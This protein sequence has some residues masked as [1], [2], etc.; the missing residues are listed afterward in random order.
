MKVSQNRANPLKTV[1]PDGDW[2]LLIAVDEAENGQLA[3][4]A[5]GTEH[6]S[7]KA[8]VDRSN[9]SGGATETTGARHNVG[10]FSYGG[11]ESG[12]RSV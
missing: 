7:P 1:R 2:M 8:G 5:Q 9:R 6:S 10:L 12:S 4:V 3:P 11:L